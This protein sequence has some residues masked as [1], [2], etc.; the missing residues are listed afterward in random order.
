MDDKAA[1]QK[2]LEPQVTCKG[3]PT[4]EGVGLTLVAGLMREVNGW[5]MIVS[6]RGVLLIRRGEA[7]DLLDLPGGARYPGTLIGMTFGQAEAEDFVDALQRAKK[8]TGLLQPR[9][10]DAIFAS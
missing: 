5:L 1:L 9:H 6:G 4:N 10:R 8:S 2:A 3:R 7:P